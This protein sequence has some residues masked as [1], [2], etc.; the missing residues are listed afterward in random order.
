VLDSMIVAGDLFQM[1]G[2]GKTEGMSTEIISA[3]K[4]T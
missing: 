1:A 3:G 4:N 2:W